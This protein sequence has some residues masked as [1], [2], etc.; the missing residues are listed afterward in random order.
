MN[1]EDFLE[2]Y[3]SLTEEERFNYWAELRDL[4]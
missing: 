2:W 1:E 4:D 3:Y